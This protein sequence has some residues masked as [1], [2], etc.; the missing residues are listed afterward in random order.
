MKCSNTAIH[1]KP[2]RIPEIRFE[3]QRL[4]SFAGL[5]VYQSLFSRIGL[6]QQLAW[7]FR[8][9]TVSPIFGHGVVVL[10]LIVHRLLGYR[11]FQDT[12]YYQD[13]PMVHLLLGLKR[14]PDVATVSR[15]LA[16]LDDASVTHLRQLVR[17]RVLD[18]LGGLV[19][20]RFT[21]DFD[22][23]VLL[24]GR[25]A[26]GTA[27]GFN[28]KKNGQRSYYPLFCTIAQTGQVLDV[29]HRPGNVHDSNGAKDSSW[30]AC[31]KSR[32]LC[33]AVS[34]KHACTAPFS[35]MALFAC[36]T[37]KGLSSPSAYRSG[38][39]LRSRP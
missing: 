17:Q 29:W 31:G 27:V 4:T 7:C 19:L 34:S 32:Q 15:T 30:P 37:P 33:L 12:R 18:Q 26:E 39:L 36:W 2:H 9:L 3:D 1:R 10:L 13:D 23:S 14:L 24:T 11:R 8:H 5:V 22:G 16:G 38:I 21:L 35:A 20:A 28:R 25:F 6:K